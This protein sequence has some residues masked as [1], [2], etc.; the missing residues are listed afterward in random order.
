M[1]LQAHDF[2]H[3]FLDPFGQKQRKHYFLHCLSKHFCF[4][5]SRERVDDNFAKISN[6]HPKHVKNSGD[7]TIQNTMQTQQ[8]EG[9]PLTEENLGEITSFECPYLTFKPT[10]LS[11]QPTPTP[12][13]PPR[14]EPNSSHTRSLES[15]SQGHLDEGK[16]FTFEFSNT[17][18]AVSTRLLKIQMFFFHEK[19]F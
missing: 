17:A 12:R 15:G 6:R 2:T 9:D 8:A 7:N 18:T 13:L 4:L 10:W 19:Y 5:F 1:T 14:M 11:R 3:I 16:S